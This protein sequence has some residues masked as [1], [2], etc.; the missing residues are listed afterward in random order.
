MA[1]QKENIVGFGVTIQPTP[2]TFN[3]P[4][5]TDM[6]P[7]SAPDDGSDATT[8]EDPTLTGSIF[9]APRT[10]IGR[11]GRAGATAVLRGPGGS[12]PFAA[13]AWPL[14]R[15]FMAAGF[16][17]VINA[18]AITGTATTNAATDTIVLA[19]GASSVDDFYKGMPISHA[20]IGSGAIRGMSM[21][22]EYVGSTKAAQLMETLASAIATGSYTIP[23]S[24]S[25]ILSTGLAIPLLSCSVWR[26]KVRRDYKD[27]ALTSFA[28][29]IPVANDQNTDYPSVEFAMSGT[30]VTPN[31]DQDAPSLTDAMLTT[32]PAAKA[33]K[34]AFNGIKIG[35][36]TLRLEFG[37]TTGAPPNQ[38]FDA[39]QEAY[40]V[41]SGTRTV[42]LDL[43]QTLMSV[44]N[45][46][47]LTDNQTLVPILSNWGLGAG[48]RFVVGVPNSYLD[49][50][51]PTGRNGFVG[52]SGNANPSDV[53][54]SMALALT[55]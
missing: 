35:H 18:T 28:I 2:G 5:S 23:P 37:L 14:G 36:Q 50:F 12:V 45:V 22:R 53:D 6:I 39:G 55:W 42:A 11:K 47:T 40:E 49:S 33:G 8:G 17:E 52:L 13:G 48:N 32:P 21:I 44:L 30:P 4:A 3:G 34:F 27:C 10:Y 25:Y 24:V 51:S 7:I 43:N 1:G 9:A 26:H 16:S 15:I 54:K 29:N 41:L 38:N 19:A 31:T 20:G 46:D